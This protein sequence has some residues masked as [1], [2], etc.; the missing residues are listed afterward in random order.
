MAEKV[1]Q[2]KKIDYLHVRYRIRHQFSV[3]IC[4]IINAYNNLVFWYLAGVSVVYDSVEISP[5]YSNTQG[6]MYIDEKDLIEL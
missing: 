5:F 1:L 4:L 3:H 2:G 6:D